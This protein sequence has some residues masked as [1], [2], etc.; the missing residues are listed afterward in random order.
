MEELTAARRLWSGYRNHEADEGIRAEYN[1]LE[2]LYLRNDL[3]AE[4]QPLSGWGEPSYSNQQEKARQ[5][6]E[7]ASAQEIREFFEKALRFDE[8][9]KLSTLVLTLGALAPEQKEVQQFVEQSLR[10][11]AADGIATF[12]FEVASGWINKLRR[13]SPSDAY[14][15]T[16]ALLAAATSD[17]YRRRLLLRIYASL[18]WTLQTRDL[19]PEE[20][21]LLRASGQLFLETAHTREFS[22]IVVST[23]DFEWPE[24][25]GLLENLLDR[26][27]KNHVN[28]V[29]E[30]IAS[31]V[32]HALGS[33]TVS[34]EAKTAEVQA[35]NEEATTT[36]HLAVVES[37]KKEAG[38]EV[39]N[40]L[41]TWLLDQ[42]I[43][44]PDLRGLGDTCKWHLDQ[45]VNKLGRQP[46]PWLFHTLQQRLDR[47]KTS[48]EDR[49]SAVSYRATLTSYVTPIEAESDLGNTETI[50]A[51]C[52]LIGLAGSSS[53]IGFY[54]PEILGDIDPQGLA[55][56]AEI[57]RRIT[58]TTDDDELRALAKF[59]QAYPISGS[60]WRQIAAPV[61]QIA[62]AKSETERWYLYSHLTERPR[63]AWMRSHGDVAVVF[64]EAVQ[65][66]RDAL[67]AETEP[68]FKPYWRWQLSRAEEEL[69][70]QEQDAQEERGE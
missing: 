15:A 27:P 41:A 65:A 42:L 64:V 38:V 6:A 40:G 10:T 23:F 11:T 62:E 18:R 14:L 34:P 57:A 67:T 69:Q 5:L 58:S 17:D 13:N 51:V 26:C 48:G 43:R 46:L 12:V 47:E 1:R 59:S 24:L 4:F 22:E 63:Q 61:L 28:D 70:S 56:P 68:E 32:H 66:A 52:D 54:L 30:G 29:I 7:T 19:Q 39:P 50:G 49:F 16:K 60:P 36:Q 33:L 21:R 25:R 31:A 45:I 8:R 2:G 9:S 20:H 55:V 37:K 53:S 35:S 3:A 44:V